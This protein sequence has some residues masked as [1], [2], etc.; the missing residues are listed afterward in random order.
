MKGQKALTAALC[1]CVLALCV[2]IGIATHFRQESREAQ[3]KLTMLQERNDLLESELLKLGAQLTQAEEEKAA[4]EKER[5]S[6]QLQYEWATERNNPV[7]RYYYAEGRPFGMTTNEM[8][9]DTVFYREAWK[10]EFDYAVKKISEY[11]SISQEYLDRPIEED[12]Q[13]LIEYKE[14]I[15]K[16]V[17]MTWDLSM[18]H[19]SGMGTNGPVTV[20]AAEATVYRQGT[21]WLLERYYYVLDWS[22]KYSFAFNEDTVTRLWEK[23]GDPLAE[24]VQG[25]QLFPP[26]SEVLLDQS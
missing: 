8:H 24:R 19:K 12:L 22:E 23:I 26:L 20:A 25:E 7:D 9:A 14:L 16:V 3:A 6:A 1:C 13:H 5:A 2:A 17:G 21:I 15:E 4:A 18:L 11:C 10:E